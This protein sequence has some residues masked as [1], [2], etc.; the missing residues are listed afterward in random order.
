MLLRIS[1]AVGRLGHSVIASI[2]I[3]VVVT[4]ISA[5]CVVDGQPVQSPGARTTESGVSMKLDD[6][7]FDKVPLNSRERTVCSPTSPSPKWRGV[8]IQAPQHAALPSSDGKKGATGIPIC[9]L[10]TL[11]IASIATSTPLTLVAIDAQRGETFRGA[12]IDE[13]PSP[14]VPAP[15][16]KPLDPAQYQGVATSSYFNPDLTRYVM[17]PRRPAVYEVFAEYGGAVSNRV[18]IQVVLP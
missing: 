7:L 1:D 12:V 11:D 14:E 18:T 2:T 8:L 13:D 6:Q 4:G 3:I 16:S 17:L 9:G 15:N 10:Y 5:S